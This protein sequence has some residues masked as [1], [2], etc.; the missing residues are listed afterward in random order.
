MEKIAALMERAGWPLQV[1][2]YDQWCRRLTACT[3]EENVLRILSCLFTDQRLAGESL[4]ERFGERQ[5]RF[6]TAQADALLRQSGIRCPPVNA[7]LMRSYLR[8]FAAS[9][10]LPRPKGVRGVLWRGEGK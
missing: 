10:Y 9:G 7:A 3:A 4:I 5:A 6:S 2:P 1:V 8:H